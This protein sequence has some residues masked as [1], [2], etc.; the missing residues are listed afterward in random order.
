MAAAKFAAVGGVPTPLAKA[1][2]LSAVAWS[3]RKRVISA[4]KVIEMVS[5]MVP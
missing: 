5:A 2:R 3:A 1:A 4:D